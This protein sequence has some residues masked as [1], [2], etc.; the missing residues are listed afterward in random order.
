MINLKKFLFLI[1]TL[2]S[3]SRTIHGDIVWSTPSAISTAFTNASDPHVVIDSNGNATA[4]WIENST[5]KAS[6]LLLGGSWS[7]PVTLS[8]ELNV[9]SSLKLGVDSSGNVT[10]LWIENTQIESATHPFGGSWS[11]ETAPISDTGASNPSLAVDAS[12]NAVAVWVRN[13]VI[14]SSTR[15]SGGWQSFTSL[16]AA[17]SNNP[18]VAIS[19]AGT[20]IALWHSVV[21]GSDTIV[22]DILNISKNTW[23]PTKNVFNATPAFLHNYP[24][25]AMDDS[26]NAAVAW[27]R[28]NLVNG[29][30]YQNV[31]VLA[32]SLTVNASAWA[33]PTILSNSGIRNPANLTI[34][35]GFDTSGDALAVWTN[36]YDGSSFNVESD[37]KL[38]GASWSGFMSPQGPSLYSFGIDVAL[39]SGAALLTNMTWDGAST[40]CIQSQQTD[41]IAPLKQSWTRTNVF[42]TGNDNGYPQCALSLTE[43]TFNAVAVWIHFDGTNNIIHASTGADSVIAPPKNVTATQSVADFGVY[44]DYINTL[45]WDPSEDQNVV[46]YNIYRNGIFFAVSGPGTLQFIDHNATQGGT[47]TYGVAALTTSSRQ[48][49]IVS[50]TLNP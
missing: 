43:N 15:V 36:S 33:I 1:L 23:G 13:G 7:Q 49:K 37:R 4:A 48:S 24:V 5:I 50:F 12:G 16:S 14:Q 30:S 42:S 11:L 3:L 41:T 10:A 40:I 44:Q 47:V 32:S 20:A 35:L 45:T 28:Y 2:C 29:K 26:G 18:Y 19:N 22:T 38:F 8:N 27:F 21:A 6:S 25:V 17:N 31:Q 39:S 9:S 34:K 46:Q